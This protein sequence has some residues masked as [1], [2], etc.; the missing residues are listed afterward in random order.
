VI[1]A[2][3]EHGQAYRVIKVKENRVNVVF[4]DEYQVAAQPRRAQARDG[5]RRR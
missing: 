2:C 4:R 1:A 3:Q 5:R